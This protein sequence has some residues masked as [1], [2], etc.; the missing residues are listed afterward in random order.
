[1]LQRLG[2]AVDQGIAGA[3]LHLQHHMTLWTQSSKVLEIRQ[4]LLDSRDGRYKD[5]DF[6]PFEQEGDYP[7][8]CPFQCGED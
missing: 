5:K 2:H 6:L 4:S 7:D 3:E 1:M 8:D